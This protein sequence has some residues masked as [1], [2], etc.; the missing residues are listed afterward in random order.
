MYKCSKCGLEVI[1]LKD[2]IIRACKCDAVVIAE[3]STKIKGLGKV[4]ND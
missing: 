1:V 4:K 3:A 2:K